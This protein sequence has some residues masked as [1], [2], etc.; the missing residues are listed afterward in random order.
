MNENA[1]YE[2]LG[3]GI[4]G[5][6]CFTSD[7][8]ALVGPFGKVHLITGQNNSGKSALANI[9]GDADIFLYQAY[10]ASP[11]LRLLPSIVS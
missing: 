1:P 5:Y 4:G 11:S 10:T 7:Q 3:F 8:Q 9:A 2:F 6:R